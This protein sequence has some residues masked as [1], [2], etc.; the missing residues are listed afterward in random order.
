MT[1]KSVQYARVSCSA[2]PTESHSIQAHV[3]NGLD[4]LLNRH[5]R[6]LD[7]VSSPDCILTLCLSCDKS[8]F[9]WVS[10]LMKQDLGLEV[11]AGLDSA[12]EE[13]VKAHH[14]FFIIEKKLS[15]SDR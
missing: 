5:C 9:S 2:R 8:C 6:D 4:Q 10:Q 3:R 7:A 13:A 12:D 1:S 11:V 15:V 14:T